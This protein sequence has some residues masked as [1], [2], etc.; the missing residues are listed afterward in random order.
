M[1]AHLGG[2]TE[3]DAA[4][5]CLQG[6]NVYVDTSSSIAFIGR[7][8]ALESIYQFGTDRVM[9][10]TDFPMW[11]ASEELERFFSLGLSEE[12]NRAVLYGNFARLYKLDGNG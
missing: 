1:A 7:D 4:R 6:P 12:E 5:E 10:G 3:W 8:E 11:M 2:Y 9:F